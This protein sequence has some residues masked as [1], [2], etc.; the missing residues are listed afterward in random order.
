[1]EADVDVVSE[2]FRNASGLKQL[3]DDV[4][5]TW[6]ATHSDLTTRDTIA[7]KAKGSEVAVQMLLHK[8]ALGRG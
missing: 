4:A 1:M 7:A 3:D 6:L 5:T 8:L 2:V